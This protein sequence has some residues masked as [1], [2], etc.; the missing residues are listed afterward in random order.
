VSVS[1]DLEPEES[2]RL[3]TALAARPYVSVRDE[4]S[5]LRL[6]RAGIEREVALVPDPLLLLPRAFPEELLAR[7]LE[8]LKHM[9]WFPRSGDP[10]VI[11]QG[12]ALSE[13]ADELAATLAAALER[14]P[15]PVVL[16]DLGRGQEDS[17]LADALS[18]HPFVPTFRVPSIAAV[19]DTVAVL[20]HSRAFV[21]TSA[22]ASVA[23]SAFGVP[24]LVLDRTLGGSLR[25][26][27][28]AIRKLL[29]VPAGTGAGPEETAQLDAHFDRLAGLAEAALVRRLRR[30]G[31]SEESLL[32]R[33][34]E[35][36]QVL[37]SWRTAHAARS[38]QV[39]DLRLRSAA[40][41][42]ETRK[43]EAQVQ[44]LRDEAARRHHAWAAVTEE[45]AT[46]RTQREDASR[47]LGNEREI[48]ARALAERDELAREA[49]GIRARQAEVQNELAESRRESEREREQLRQALVAENAAARGEKR[50]AEEILS[51]RIDLDRVRERLE[52]A[53]SDYSELR[54]SHALLFTEIA[55][56][57]ADA[58]RS[59]EVVGELQAELERLQGLLSELTGRE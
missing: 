30:E 23:A 28:T 56:T 6:R 52:K 44:E 15:I 38:Q 14:S 5:R 47:E 21:G 18:S 9:G 25:E 53:R 24:A 43:L 1:F 4:A 32:A 49:E 36:E 19:S 17:R 35:N 46:E 39:V 31:P 8:Y 40:L 20:A 50:A 2:Q 37:D 55:E 51:L 59:S 13:R 12:P 10:L 11:Q 58:G 26:L 29:R 27:P 54:I 33:L 34:R 3:R 22:R 48:S 42:D 45:L 16:L 57:R 7:R 41:S